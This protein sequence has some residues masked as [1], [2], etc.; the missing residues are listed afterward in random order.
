MNTKGVALPGERQGITENNNGEM[1][2]VSNNNSTTE[3][4]NANEAM[5][6]QLLTAGTIKYFSEQPE[7]REWLIDH[8]LP[9]GQ[10]VLLAGPGAEGENHGKPRGAEP[11]KVSKAQSTGEKI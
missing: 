2:I 11:F 9:K 10:V 5:S 8:F 4:K 7:P 6:G 3:Q 1:G